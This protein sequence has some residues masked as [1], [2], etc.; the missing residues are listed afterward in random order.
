LK[1]IELNANEKYAQLDESLPVNAS[2]PKKIQVGELS[3]FGDQTIVLFYK[4]FSTSYAY[5][6]IGYIEHANEL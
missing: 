3:L 6:N 5:T 4:S 2:I 1:L